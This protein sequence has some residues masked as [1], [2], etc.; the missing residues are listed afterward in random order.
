MTQA[1]CDARKGEELPPRRQSLRPHTCHLRVPGSPRLA[2]REIFRPFGAA[3]ARVG[4]ETP[5]VACAVCERP[6]LPRVPR[7][8][9][10][11]SEGR[12]HKFESC[13]ARHG[14]NSLA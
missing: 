14:I 11:P 10:L 5:R 13:R 4:E 6:G 2:W 12:G 9:P 3:L 1:I 8:E 7:S